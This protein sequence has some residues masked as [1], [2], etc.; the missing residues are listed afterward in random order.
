MEKEINNDM[1]ALER[2]LSL[3]NL[4]GNIAYGVIGGVGFEQF[5]SV[6]NN[7]GENNPEDVFN[8]V[9]SGL[10]IGAAYNFGKAVERDFNADCM[11]YR[12]NSVSLSVPLISSFVASYN[13]L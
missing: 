7:F 2:T 12:I 10:F 11:R 9:I 8:Y 13:L 3:K 5:L 1:N 4:S 6:M